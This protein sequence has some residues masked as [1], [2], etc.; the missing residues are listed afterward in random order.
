M[1]IQNV[2]IPVPAEVM[3]T[4]RPTS[5]TKRLIWIV[6]AVVALFIFAYLL[7][8]VN[9][10]RLAN[11]FYSSAE[12]SYQEGRYLDA[13]IGYD[14]I[15]PITN[16]RTAHG[17]YYQV[18]RLWGNKGALPKPANYTHSVSQIDEIIQQKLDISTAEAFIQMYTGRSHPYFPDIYL[19]LGHLYEESGDKQTALEIYK[20]CAKLFPTRPDITQAAIDQLDRLGVN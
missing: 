2:P 13:L 7:A 14:E 1:S 10:S 20:E 16:T 15:D 19:R 11:E 3:A 6:L 9:S 5:L 17:G 18:T 8:W 4:P 12:A